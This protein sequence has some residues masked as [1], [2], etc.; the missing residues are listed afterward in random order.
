MIPPSTGFILNART[1]GI[2]PQEGLEGWCNDPK[3]DTRLPHSI[4][5]L[6]KIQ[7]WLTAQRIE[8]GPLC[9]RQKWAETNRRVGFQDVKRDD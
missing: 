7:E 4:R 8:M 6:W 3:S 2:V 9:N 1:A 5:G